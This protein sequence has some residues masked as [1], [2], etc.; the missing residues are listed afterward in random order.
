MRI[1]KIKFDE[2][3]VDDNQIRKGFFEQGE[4]VKSILKH[5]LI[6]PL[7]VQKEKDGYKLIDGERRYRAIKSIIE[8][9][10][11]NVFSKSIDCIIMP[12]PTNTTITQLITD[13]H[14]NKILPFEEAEAYKK[15]IERD[16]LSISEVSFLLGI[17]KTRIAKRL[18]LL[19]FDND[20]KKLIEDKKISVAVAQSLDI[21]TIKRKKNVINKIADEGASISR[22][23]EILLEDEGS[24]LRLMDRMFE[25][26]YSVK[27]QMDFLD[28]ILKKISRERGINTSNARSKI[29]NCKDD[30]DKLNHSINEIYESQITRKSESNKTINTIESDDSIEETAL[31]PEEAKLLN[32]M[33][34]HKEELK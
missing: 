16:G 18:K 8:K 4:M 2:I 28:G 30:I 5:G 31:L 25:K 9:T 21:N 34:K 7:K 32:E 17:D 14:K 6:D 3:I 10:K 33:K 29:D 26:L 1:N 12:K 22:A 20:T 13:I 23:K 11:D 24:Y 15:V 27:N 19:A